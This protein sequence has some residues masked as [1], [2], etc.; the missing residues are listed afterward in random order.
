MS[1]NSLDSR[2]FIFR[3]RIFS[4]SP[5]V[6]LTVTISL[7]IIFILPLTGSYWNGVNFRLTP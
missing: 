3:E 1:M 4:P 5:P 2:T 6:V 7:D